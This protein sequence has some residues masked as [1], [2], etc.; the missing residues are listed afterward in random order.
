[1]DYLVKA[2]IFV[3][4]MLIVYRFID[5]FKTYLTNV[6]SNLP[7]TSLFCQFG[8]Y[9]GLSIFFTILVSAFATKQALNFVK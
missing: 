8:V 3:P 5:Y 2:V 6:I 7:Y 9:D 4:F 1:M